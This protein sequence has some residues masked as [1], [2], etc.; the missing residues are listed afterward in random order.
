[1]VQISH[2]PLRSAFV[3]LLFAS[4][5]P[6]IVSTEASASGERDT[7]FGNGGVSYA[8][9]DGYDLRAEAIAIQDDGKPILVGFGLTRD[10]SSAICAVARFQLDG[11]LDASFGATRIVQVTFGVARQFCTAALIQPD[12]KVLVIGKREYGDEF[13]TEDQIV[14]VRLL[15]DGNL[16]TAFGNGGKVILAALHEYWPKAIALQVDGKILIGSPEGVARLEPTGSFDSTFG[17]EGIAEVQSSPQPI[18]F[19]LDGRILVQTTGG[20]FALLEDGTV[21]LTFGTNGFVASQTTGAIIVQ[22]DGKFVVAG[23]QSNNLG[24][25]RVV[26][27]RF[28]GDGA[29]DS[30]F[31]VDGRA[32]VHFG[33]AGDN[34][35]F[36]GIAAQPNERIVLVAAASLGDS[37]GNPSSAQGFARLTRDGG[38]DTSFGTE[39]KT[40]VSNGRFDGDPTGIAVDIRK[41]MYDAANPVVLSDADSGGFEVNRLLAEVAPSV[42]WDVVPGA[43]TSQTK[44]DVTPGEVVESDV[45]VVSGLDADVVVPAVIKSCSSQCALVSSTFPRD[46]RYLLVKNGDEIRIRHV[47][48]SGV[49]ATTET[50]VEIGGFG[51]PNVMGR[52]MG[53]AETI[54]FS[55][56]TANLPP[57]I[58]FSASPQSVPRNSSAILTW[59]STYGNAC[60][61]SG[62]WSGNRP[63]SG[64]T[65]TGTLQ[66]AGTYVYTLTCQGDGGTSSANIS[67]TVTPL[68]APT[69]TF[70]ATPSPAG[71]GKPVTLSWSSTGASDRSCAM[72]GN[73]G[74]GIGTDVGVAPSGSLVVE[75]LAVGSYVY[76]LTCTSPDGVGSSEVNLAVT[77][78]NS[79]G[80]G[81][82]KNLLFLFWM[83][84]LTK[85][86]ITRRGRGLVGPAV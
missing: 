5:L 63:L 46:A 73:A 81:L 17:G 34:S 31:G 37:T 8:Y 82:P 49:S 69:V 53:N 75:G 43:F 39:G 47:A 80:G 85:L 45:Y 65:S 59:S 33:E 2:V 12:G 58:S 50:L 78:P 13:S 16:D 18:A 9:L 6:L 42:P 38:F 83:A 66:V 52:S 84:A 74:S 1:M 44:A 60:T 77:E 56:T 68:A 35:S 72:S 76:T 23:T 40:I 25:Q 29:E 7:S 27:Y 51:P 86:R 64:S 70:S 4:L 67:V 57:A 20:V 15:S 55:S 10:V 11:Q 19:G 36:A 79:S 26:L 30:T 54:R 61:A 28:T 41:L 62:N 24:R 14:V 48:A 22:R 3:K 71:R 21:D 32:T